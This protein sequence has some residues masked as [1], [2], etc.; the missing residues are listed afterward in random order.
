MSVLFF[1][2]GDNYI[3]DMKQ[4]KSYQ[5]NQNNQLISNLNPGDHVWAFTRIDQ[6]YVMAADLVV[7][8]TKANPP[9]HE[10]GKYCAL[11][12]RKSSHYFDVYECPDV[13]PV[14]RSL[15]FSPKAKILGQSFQ[16]RNGVRPLTNAD[17]QL[18]SSFSA[19]L[20]TI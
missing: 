5:L 20:N 8:Q 16:G 10:Y 13:E 14:I 2:T 4:G 1:W 12:D 11:A 7:I 19:G 6:T 17:E 15:S 9:G 3:G 18:L